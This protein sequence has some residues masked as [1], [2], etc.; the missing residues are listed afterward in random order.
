MGF[1]ISKGSVHEC[2]SLLVMIGKRGHLSREAYQL[3]STE[4]DEIAAMISGLMR[5]QR[6]EGR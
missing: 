2:V 3:H 4:A 1:K 6:R 5:A